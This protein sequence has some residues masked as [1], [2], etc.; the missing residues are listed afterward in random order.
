M[1]RTQVLLIVIPAVALGVLGG[2]AGGIYG[3]YCSIQNTKTPA[4]RSFVLRY[5]IAVWLAVLLLIVLPLVL[6]FAGLIDMWLSWAAWA[7]FFLLLVPSIFWANRRQAA[8][9]AE[10]ATGQTGSR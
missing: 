6:R 3:T 9:R 7:L 10:D 4:E 5:S 8:L 2:L 1:D